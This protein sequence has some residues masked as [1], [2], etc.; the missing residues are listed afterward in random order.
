MGFGNLASE[1]SQLAEMLATAGVTAPQ[2]M[3]LHLKV[4]E[5]LVRGLG[6]RSAR[7]VMTRADLLVLEVMIHLAEGYRRRTSEQFVAARQRYLPGFA[8]VAT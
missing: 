1:M 8:D 4:L 6:A 5:E 7:H 3:L 2:M